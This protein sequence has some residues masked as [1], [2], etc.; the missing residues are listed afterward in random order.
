[1]P[2][3]HG[4]RFHFCVDS[5]VESHHLADGH[6]ALVNALAPSVTAP[7]KICK[8]PLFVNPVNASRDAVFGGVFEGRNDG[9]DV[10]VTFAGRAREVVG[11][12]K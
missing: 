11:L 3:V 4:D 5:V 9:A 10:L 12:A 6:F 1:M 8:S 2:A 7:V